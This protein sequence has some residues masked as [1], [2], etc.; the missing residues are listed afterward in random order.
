MSTRELYVNPVTGEVWKEGE[1]IT[2]PTMAK[3]L[4]II[5]EEGPQAIHN[6]SLTARLVQDIQSHGGIVT[7]EDLR[8]YK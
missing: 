2:E 5:A 7:E 8:N 1:Y 6:G 4:D 3:T